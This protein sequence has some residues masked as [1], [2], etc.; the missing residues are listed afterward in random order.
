M[1]YD[2]I[3]RELLMRAYRVQ[4]HVTSDLVHYTGKLIDITRGATLLNAGIMLPNAVA[5]ADD[6]L[7]VSRRIGEH[8]AAYLADP[9]GYENELLE[10]VLANG[11]SA[12]LP[13]ESWVDVEA[14][15]LARLNVEAAQ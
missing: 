1:N 13:G 7:A 3:D 4:E 11:R 6:A 14:W 12:T 5:N 10:L 2:A 8:I 15:A 9:M